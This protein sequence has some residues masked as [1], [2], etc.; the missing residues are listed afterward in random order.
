MKIEIDRK[1]NP[2]IQIYI[3]WLSEHIGPETR[4]KFKVIQGEYWLMM[5]DYEKLEVHIDDTALAVQFRL[6]FSS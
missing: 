3:N 6:E 5:I 1:F 2:D 4:R